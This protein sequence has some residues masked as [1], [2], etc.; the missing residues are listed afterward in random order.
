[1]NAPSSSFYSTS[2]TNLV[3]FVELASDSILLIAASSA[4]FMASG[5]SFAFAFYA[6]GS[7]IPSIV[8]M[9]LFLLSN[10]I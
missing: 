3:D 7:F 2:L 1:M 6:S 8:L 5:S 4:P 10:I 9:L